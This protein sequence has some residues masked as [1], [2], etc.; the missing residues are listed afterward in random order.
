MSFAANIFGRDSAIFKVG[1]VLGLGIP[2]WLD[3]KFGAPETEGPR[4]SDLAVQTSTYGTAI[5]RVYGTIAFAGN[6]IWLEGGKLRE[7]VKK[8]KRG[9]KGGG[10][11]EPDKT[12]TYFA[13]FHLA[14]CEGPIAG[15]RRIWCS[16]KLIYDA[17]SDDLETIIASNDAA[18]GWTLYRGTDDQMPDPRYEADVGVE[19]ASAHRGLAY[20]AFRD[21]N[22]TDF[23]NTLEGAQFRVE[24]VSAQQQANATLLKT[25]AA[26][27]GS[28]Y[29]N[30][31]FPT[32]IDARLV[33]IYASGS[34]LKKET[35]Y[36]SRS[37]VSYID[38]IPA[39]TSLTIATRIISD[40]PDIRFL[41]KS[42][43]YADGVILT[44]NFKD[45]MQCVYTDNK[46]FV[47]RRGYGIQ[48]I[49]AYDGVY[50]QNN[51]LNA[52][53]ITQSGNNIFAVGVVSGVMWISRLDYDLAVVEAVPIIH[54]GSYVG[55]GFYIS[56]DRGVC[57]IAPS[58]SGSQRVYGYDV[59][60]GEQVFAS[61]WI[62][63][64]DYGGSHGYPAHIS[65]G[66]MVQCPVYAGEQLVRVFSIGRASS[67]AAPL[68]SVIIKEVE[69]A[70]LLAASDVDVS[71]L[72]DQVKG[73]QISGGSIR[74][75][76]EPLATAF[77]FDVIQS[78]YKIKFV[79]RGGASVLTV[80]YEDLGATAGDTPDSVFNQSREMDTQLPAKTTVSY[81]DA[82][83]E[84]EVSE[85]SAARINTEAV[86]EE[87]VELAI[88]LGVD[89]A[90]G[91]A[92][93]L[94]NRAWLERTSM[95]FTLPPTYLGLESADVVTVDAKTAIHEVVIRE[96][97]Y[98]EDGRLEI[99]GV[100][101]NAAIFVPNASGGEGHL[102]PSTIGLPGP[103]LFLP[104]DI[105]LVDEVSQNAPGFVGAMTGYTDGWPGATAFRSADEGQTWTDVQ[106]YSGKGGIGSA[107]NALTVNPG[108]LIDQ[109]TLNVLMISGEPEGITYDQL[110]TGYNY[111]AYGLDGRWEIVRFQNAALQGDGSYMLSGFVR[112]DKGTEWATGLH[113]PGDWFVLLDDPDNA[114]IGVATETI[115]LDRLYRGITQRASI[116]TGTD[117]EFSYDAVNLEPLSP[118]YAKATRDGS[119]NLSATFVRRSRIGSTWWGNGVEAPIGEATQSYQIDVIKAGAVIRTIE[120]ATPTFAY[121]AADQVTD[122]GSTQSS[123]L[124]R[125][126]QLSE[127]VGRGFVREVTL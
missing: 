31:V 12:Y 48:A 67:Q 14:L 17:G 50:A 9:G 109:S 108:Y 114:F 62:Q 90:A 118:V 45:T 65:G 63:D 106:G 37:V 117:V 5:P 89:E 119:G 127:V 35:Y 126:Y 2:G 75:A 78:G 22:L 69:A 101:S 25:F 38:N 105:P 39:P 71:M 81:L 8:N 13:T 46:L 58:P 115:G 36:T 42:E 102:P 122:F 15:V 94:Q 72:I 120:S 43:C 104:L 7:V 11:T 56:V 97:N 107:T 83:R 40:T 53:S 51:S 21:W 49:T 99:K 3:K 110:L 33:D 28:I 52:L 84:Y 6:V 95:P 79:P 4:L 111:A 24:V 92:E 64:A 27:L 29:G 116:E 96:I 93:I 85:Q 76:L 66:I 121:S 100:P 80:P 112:G 124:F 60:T 82:A 103:S 16:D 19:N 44:G 70:S 41:S 68:S 30:I 54:P 87:D 34:S 1:N 125:I 32:N 86:N 59:S 18:R 20:L 74:S 47:S 55:D 88:V 77:Q 113:Q 91:I 10:S 57:Y 61:S 73:Y 23:G 123:I 26:P 98:T